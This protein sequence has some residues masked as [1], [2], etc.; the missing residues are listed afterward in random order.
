MKLLIAVIVTGIFIWM[1]LIMMNETENGRLPNIKKLV[2][3]ICCTTILS[4]AVNTIGL[5]VDYEK[6]SF[7]KMLAPLLM[8]FGLLWSCTLFTRRISQDI[9]IHINL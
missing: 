4:Y 6:Y 3:A 9:Y 8:L 1:A 7:V 5:I 2:R